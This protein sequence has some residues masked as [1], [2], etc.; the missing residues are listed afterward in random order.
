L[1]GD[2]ILSPYELQYFYEEQQSRIVILGI[3][4]LEFS[5]VFCQMV[6]MLHCS[7]TGNLKL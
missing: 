2:G 7:A 5:N 1:D 6:D 3:E 4:P